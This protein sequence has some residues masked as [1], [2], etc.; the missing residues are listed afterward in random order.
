MNPISADLTSGH[1]GEKFGEITENLRAVEWQGEWIGLPEPSAPNQWLCFRAPLTVNA[2]PPV[3]RVRIACDSKYWLWLNGEL[4]IF[5]G[6]L[7][8]GPTPAGTYFDVV[9]LAG[10]LRPGTNQV[11]ILLWYFGKHGLS[12][13][14]SG[15]AALLVDG[16]DDRLALRT[17]ASWKVSVHPAYGETPPPHPNFRLTESNLQFDARKDLVGWQRAAYDDRNWA[18]AHVLGTPPA[19]PWGC[20]EPRPI[21]QWRN[22]GILPF[23]LGGEFPRPSDGEPIVVPLPYNAQVTPWFRIDAP[24]GLEVDLRTDNYNNFPNGPSVRSI[25]VTREGVQDYESL[26]WMNGHFVHYRFP[27]GVTVLALGYRETGYDAD[28]TGRFACDDPLLNTLWQ[29]AQRTLYVNM[30]DTYMDCPDRERSQWWGDVV[31]GLGEAFYVFD[32]RR[33]PPI[34]RKAILEVAAWQRADGVMYSPVPAGIPDKVDPQNPIPHDGTWWCELPQQMLAAVGW[35]GFWTYFLY[36]EDRETIEIVYPAVRR[37]LLLWELDASGTVMHRAG[38]WDWSDWGRN[39]DVPLLDQAWYFLALK[40]AAAM[41]R[42]TGHTAEGCEFERR[43]RV[44]AAAF[45][46]TFWH[47]DCYK[48]TGHT[49]DPDD[50]ANGLAVVAGLAKPEHFPA[51][52]RVLAR[53]R[54]AGPYMEK[55]VLESLFLM[56]A[57]DEALMRMKSRYQRMLEDDITTLWENF[58]GG[59]DR[60]GR[61]TYNHAWSGGPLTL[62]SQ[63]VAGIA[64]LEPGWTVFRVRPQLGNLERVDAVVPTPH[65][66]IIAAVRRGTD[67]LGIDLTIPTGASAIVS[68]PWPAGHAWREIRVDG[69]VFPHSSRSPGGESMRPPELRLGPGAHHIEGIAAPSAD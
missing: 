4:V 17:D 18:G 27:V 35:Y 40:G 47:G 60:A 25:Y 26:G 61:G 3:A 32:A 57:A 69:G 41:A 52:R 51:I 13:N 1:V 45:E 20:L 55:Y 43:M 48:S 9:D 2:A 33:G 19:A 44:M 15:R 8:R 23:T 67:S 46:E 65:G 11:A 38:G 14:S 54:F 53:S 7:K 63:Y 39:A 42:L 59:E 28:F 68:L 24:A 30:R 29:R 6:Q 58:G 62:L 5:E 36:S 64:P 37:Y 31:T 50:R 16:S 21:P 66:E 34:T 22:S 10:W 49:G 12:H 56:D